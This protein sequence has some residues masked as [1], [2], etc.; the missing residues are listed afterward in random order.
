MLL[1]FTVS[2]YKSFKEPVTLSMIAESDEDLPQNVVKNAQGSGY[3]VLTSAVVYGANA[4]GKSNLLEA[5]DFFVDFILSSTKIY[6]DDLPITFSPFLLDPNFHDQPSRF[7]VDFLVDGVR[8]NYGFAMTRSKVISEWLSWYPKGRRANLFLRGEALS[9]A[10]KESP[11]PDSHIRLFGWDDKKTRD[12]IAKTRDRVLFL[13]VCDQ[14]D[15]TGV[16]KIVDTICRRMKYNQFEDDIALNSTLL[17]I[18]LEDRNFRKAIEKLMCLADTGVCGFQ[19]KKIG[20]KE[21]LNQLK[22]MGI[23]LDDFKKMLGSEGNELGENHLDRLI[24]RGFFHNSIDMDGNQTKTLMPPQLESRGT[25]KFFDIAAGLVYFTSKYGSV[26]TIDEFDLHLHIHLV[27]E[28]LRLYHAL[29]HRSGNS[30]LILTTHN[31]ELIDIKSNIFRRDQIWF[32][33]K[34]P[35]GHSACI[36]FGILKRRKGRNFR[37]MVSGG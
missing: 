7:E 18:A 14:W 10:G 25:M 24:E 11:H 22:S 26:L 3:D 12:N 27:R 17:H 33:E 30:Q 37:K 23:T 21:V 16:R 19:I 6:N 1:E 28:L 5:F 2:N 9:K 29:A 32:V 20:E 35:A 31:T 4:S 15:R 34:M 36:H 8:H 13:S